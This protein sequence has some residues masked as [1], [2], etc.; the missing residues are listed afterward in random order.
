[1]AAITAIR[2]NQV[3]RTFAQRLQKAGKQPKVVITACMRKL[4][5]M[6][7]AIARDKIIWSPKCQLQTV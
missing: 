1:M 3:I 7:N 2:C 4:L 6:L 5:T